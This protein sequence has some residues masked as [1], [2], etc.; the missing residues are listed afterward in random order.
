MYAKDICKEA[1]ETPLPPLRAINHVIT[2][3]DAHRVYAWRPAHCP[4]PLCPLW[5]MER[6]D[7]LKTGR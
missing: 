4:E 7:Y 6:D 1:V 2:L 3:I 5:R